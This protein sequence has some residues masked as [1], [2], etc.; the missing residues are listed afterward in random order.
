ML[1]ARPVCLGRP[2]P[3]KTRPCGRAFHGSPDMASRGVGWWFP[4]TR[5]YRLR[6]TAPIAPRVCASHAPRRGRP[7]GGAA[8]WAARRCRLPAC[9]AALAVHAQTGDG[10]D[11]SDS[12][13]ARADSGRATDRQLGARPVKTG[14]DR[15]DQHRCPDSVTPSRRHGARPACAC[16]PSRAGDATQEPARGPPMPPPA[17]AI[18]ILAQPVPILH[19]PPSAGVTMVTAWTNAGPA[20]LTRPSP[21]RWN[22]VPRAQSSSA[23]QTWIC[24]E[25]RIMNHD[26]QSGD[27]PDGH[28]GS[29]KLDTRTP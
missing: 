18:P 19:G 16:G 26:G 2:K 11:D 14:S 21:A 10:T 28:C 17:H 22:R 24:L 4:R 6:E 1:S 23:F 7:H 9:T 25:W 12:T 8:P 15:R 27:H 13:G 5:H 20:G 29:G 3:R